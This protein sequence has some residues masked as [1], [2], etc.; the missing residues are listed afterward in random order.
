MLDHKLDVLTKVGFTLGGG[1][2][3]VLYGDY[4]VIMGVLAGMMVADYITGMLAGGRKAGLSSKVGYIG[5]K[6]KLAML[7]IVSMGHGV[8]L[9]LGTQGLWRDLA[10]GFYIGNEALSV[11]ENVA[12]LDVLVPIKLKQVLTRLIDEDQLQKDQEEGK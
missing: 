10:C 5:I 9:L 2:F 11:L 6:R 4:S 8:D 3:G 12:R 1:L 7:I